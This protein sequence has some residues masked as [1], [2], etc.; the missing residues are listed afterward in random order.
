MIFDIYFKFILRKRNC[1]TLTPSYLRNVSVATVTMA[2]NSL[3]STLSCVIKLCVFTILY[4]QYTPFLDFFVLFVVVVVATV[5][6]VGNN[7]LVIYWSVIL[8]LGTIICLPEI[9][10]GVYGVSVVW[11][12]PLIFRHFHCHRAHSRGELPIWK[13]L[14][15]HNPSGPHYL[16]PDGRS[17]CGWILLFRMS[18]VRLYP[19]FCHRRCRRHTHSCW[20]SPFGKRWIY[21]NPSGNYHLRPS[22][23]SGRGLS[24]LS[25]NFSYFLSSSSS[26]SLSSGSVVYFHSVSLLSL[27]SY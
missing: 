23:R 7:L 3:Q 18:F 25:T 5:I 1:C 19:I 14:V 2:I 20:E 16:P 10:A 11:L 13:G 9:E 27:F 22:G 4:D 21:H 12:S 15:F 26:H 24:C 6:V 8:P 17:W